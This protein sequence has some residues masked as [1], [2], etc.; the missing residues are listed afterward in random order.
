VMPNTSSDRDVVEVLAEE[1]VERHRRGERPALTEYTDRYP[2]RAAEIRDLFPALVVMEQL[3]AASDHTAG[4]EGAADV[5]A[6]R[7]LDRLGDYR[8]LR[9]VGR[10]GMGVVY[11]A[12]QVSLGRH[13]ALKVLPAHGLLNPTFLERFRREAKAA[14]KLHHTN[15]V[16]VFGVGEADGV[17]FYAMQFIRGEGLDRILRDVR[18]LRQRHGTTAAA[19]AETGTAFGQSV[20]HSLVAG[21]FENS[22]PPPATASGSSA[23][24]LSSAGRSDAE[25]YRSVAR[26]G[27]QAV[28]DFPDRWRHAVLAG[29]GMRGAIDQSASIARALRGGKPE[30]PVA[31]SFYS[32]ASARPHNDL[33]ALAACIEAPQPALDPAR[34]H[35]IQTP[36]LLVIGEHDELAS[37][38][39]RLVE[40]IPTARLVTVPGR[41]HLGTVPA[42]EFKEAAL[43]FLEEA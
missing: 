22:P 39:D 20:A 28:L 36:I 15:I 35:A 6:D 7:L 16:P 1:F 9:E 10:G 17:S 14:A 3:K 34:L 19:E 31:Q 42:R 41:D 21:R 25:Y 8:I 12:E 11:E 26:V 23:T 2:D 37:G 24:G 30:N 29:L 43:A 38:T 4:F 27:L 40:M 32:F 13:V 18:R 5:A 33:E